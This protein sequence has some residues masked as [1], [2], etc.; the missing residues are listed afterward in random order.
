MR[1]SV[2]TSGLD[3]TGADLPHACTAFGAVASVKV[4]KDK[5]GGQGPKNV[6]EGQTIIVEYRWAE[7]SEARLRGLAAELLQLPVDE[8][9]HHAVYALQG[10]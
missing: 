5:F 3:I 9:E 8:G 7:G 1:L 2:G 6:G 10:L 4:I